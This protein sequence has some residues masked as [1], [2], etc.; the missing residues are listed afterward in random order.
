MPAVVNTN[1]NPT[2][3]DMVQSLRVLQAYLS[4]PVSTAI[5]DQ[6][7]QAEIIKLQTYLSTVVAAGQPSGFKWPP[8]GIAKYIG[9]GKLAEN[10]IALQKAADL[11]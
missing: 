5:D 11:T 10:I 2:N 8:T 9:P 6:G 1:I 7:I 3:N 4:R